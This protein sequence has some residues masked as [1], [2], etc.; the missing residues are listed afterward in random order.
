M[1][2]TLLHGLETFDTNHTQLMDN[3]DK[4]TKRSQQQI[5]R[6]NALADQTQQ[7]QAEL[8]RLKLDS[9]AV[10]EL[11]QT[12][13]LTTQT[14]NLLDRYTETTKDLEQRVNESVSKT[15]ETADWFGKISQASSN[16]NANLNT[17]SIFE[18][19]HLTADL[20]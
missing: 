18:F 1:A 2:K 10:G 16:A 13:E 15:K 7:K 14:S 20:F 11:D 12:E 19:V 4:Q 3:L 6:L 8:Q 9:K 17:V 5:S